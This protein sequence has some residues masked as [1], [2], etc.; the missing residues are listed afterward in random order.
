MKKTTF[1]A[2]HEKLNAK[3][4]DF[5]GYKMPVQYSS[6]IAEHKAVRNS[7][8]V[9][10]VSHMGE[11]FIRGE[12]AL[13]FVNYITT[14]DASILT[15]GRVQYSAMCYEDGGIVDDLLVHRI[16]ENEFLLVVNASNK[17][18]DFE[19]MKQNNTFGVSIDD[20]SDEYSLL[21]V[22]GPN[23]KKALEKICDRP[24]D[25]EYYHFFKAKVG[26]VEM[27]VARTGYTGEL[28]YELY[29]R[30]DESI[31]ESIWNSLFD[32]GKE[33]DIQP[34]G[35]GA[36]DSLRLEMGYSLYGNDIDQNTNPI[37]AGLGWIT[38]LKKPSFIAKDILVKIK[39]EGP[40]R[41]LVAM[42]SDEKAFPRHGYDLSFD[43]KKV[44]TITSGTV[45]PILDKAIA[46][47]YVETEFVGEG[48]KI[49][50]LIRN[51]EVPAQITK[52]PFVKN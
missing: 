28:G 45:S 23:S 20:E 37:E 43:G 16:N 13:E 15:D 30:G 2:I 7:I 12:K 40:R 44:G 36:R 3:I 49:N 39:E 47:G 5:A 1:Y 4:V 11:I 41:K 42:I 10:D 8:G 14:N 38:K 18:K 19:W 27:I 33:F 48:N 17:E 9:F 26:G 50:F 21:A 52:L 46:L 31:A 22:Q 32:A 25:L 35:L 29:F 6:I 34:V 51:K 24:L